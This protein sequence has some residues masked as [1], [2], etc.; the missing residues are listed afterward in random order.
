MLEAV[1]VALEN[2]P[3][4]TPLHTGVFIIGIF[5]TDICPM[6]SY[7][8]ASPCHVSFEKDKKKLAMAVVLY[9]LIF[10]SF[11]FELVG[12]HFGST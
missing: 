4:I 12:S 5:L 7:L 10:P 1:V 11:Y 2:N 9:M 8:Y 6:C 3:A